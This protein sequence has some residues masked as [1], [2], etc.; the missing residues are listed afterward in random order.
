MITW[1]VI[2]LQ[3][4]YCLKILLGCINCKGRN[5]QEREKKGKRQGKR[6]EQEENRAEQATERIKQRSFSFSERKSV[7]FRTGC[8]SF[9]V[10]LVCRGV[11]PVHRESYP[12][13]QQFSLGS[14]SQRFSPCLPSLAPS[15]SHLTLLT[16]T[17]KALHPSQDATWNRG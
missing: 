1:N 13:A 2:I 16:D 11:D 5:K 12:S 6:P 7:C 14:R 17:P 15:P 8:I 4:L 3:F 9:P 10:S